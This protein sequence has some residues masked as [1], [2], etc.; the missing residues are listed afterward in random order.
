MNSILT[1]YTTILSC[2]I[3]FKNWKSENNRNYGNER[4]IK[5]NS[6][7]EERAVVVLKPNKHIE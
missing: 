7:T 5:I 2:A 3:E 6:N 1:G 4:I